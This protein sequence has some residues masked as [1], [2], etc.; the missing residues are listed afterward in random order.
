MIARLLKD[1]GVREYVEA[2][3]ILRSSGRTAAFVL[4][5]DLDVNPSSI[6]KEELDS[7]KR[8]GLIN[9]AGR[10]E[11]VR[12]FYRNCHV[13]VLPSYRE[14]MPRTVLEAMAAGRPVITTDAPGCRETIREPVGGWRETTEPNTWDL[15]VGRNGILIPARNA[16]ALARA[17]EFFLD[18]PQQIPA[19]GAESRFYAEERYDVDKVNAAIMQALGLKV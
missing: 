3:R 7:W 12:T 14:G 8:D 17:M 1:K 10:A 11:D 5:G 13:Y 15:K 9:Y 4:V 6:T 16:D 19:L 2:A 18:C